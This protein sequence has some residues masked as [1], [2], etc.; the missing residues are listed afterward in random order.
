MFYGY[1]VVV[2]FVLIACYCFRFA[3]FCKLLLEFVC[4]R[5][6]WCLVLF[7]CL[8]FRLFV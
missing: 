7:D 5:F 2:V 6:G 3:W 4:L 1:F 8:W